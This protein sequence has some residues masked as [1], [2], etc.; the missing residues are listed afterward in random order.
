MLFATTILKQSQLKK[1]NLVSSEWKFSVQLKKFFNT[2]S[3]ANKRREELL[4]LSV[5]SD[6]ITVKFA[7]VSD[8][9]I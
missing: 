8:L 1:W 7:S 9:S 2:I 4:D 3:I 6:E 5:K